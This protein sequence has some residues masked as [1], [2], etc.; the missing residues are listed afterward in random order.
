LSIRIVLGGGGSRMEPDWDD[1]FARMEQA[2]RAQGNNLPSVST[3]AREAADPFRV[4]VSTLISLRT[5][6]EVTVAASRRLFLLA[7]TPQAML[8]CSQTEIEKAIYPAGFYRIKAANI[9]SISRILID[10]YDGL[11][12]SDREL[13][14]K[15]PGV[16]VKTANLT[17]NLGFRIDAICVDTHVHRISNRMGWIET[18]KPE[19]SELALEKIMPRR[20]WI[21]LN[22][23]LVTFGQQ[24]C[25]PI[26]PYCSICPVSDVCEKRSVERSR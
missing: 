7:D 25:K 3:I 2:V 19:D 24:I 6:D 15:L 1:I 14:L 13:L 26:S 8:A 22:E 21:P 11:V 4:L 12:P 20:Y 18:R 5:K 9:L 23:L 10:V 16:G 17:L